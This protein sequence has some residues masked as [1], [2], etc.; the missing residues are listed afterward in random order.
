MLKSAGITQAEFE[1]PS[2]HPPSWNGSN[3]GIAIPVNGRE[4]APVSTPR[5]SLEPELASR[6]KKSGRSGLWV[7][8][9]LG[10]FVGAFGFWQYRSGNLVANADNTSRPVSAA[11]AP[12]PAPP[13]V[14][15]EPI[16]LSSTRP[17]AS[18]APSA[19]VGNTSS[20]A[21]AHAKPAPAKPRQAPPAGRPTPTG[22][23]VDVGF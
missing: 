1:L 19:R 14:L 3:S 5:V 20:S 7:G 23:E 22:T 11:P 6:F 12:A 13:P 10:A 17:A 4:S 15:P 18:V 21:P 16:P 9:A 8:A 2:M